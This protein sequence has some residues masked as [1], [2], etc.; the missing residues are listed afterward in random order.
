LYSIPASFLTDSIAMRPA[1][2][3][4]AVATVTWPGFA[5]KAAIR[6]PKVLYGAS[7]LTATT[8]MLATVRK[9]YQSWITVSSMPWIL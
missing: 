6:S 2:T 9:R 3:W 7:A 1:D 4:P 8:E 5:L